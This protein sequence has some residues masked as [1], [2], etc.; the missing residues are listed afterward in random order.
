MPHNAVPNRCRFGFLEVIIA[1]ADDLHFKILL[2]ITVL[3]IVVVL[4]SV[5]RLESVKN[6]QRIFHIV[7]EVSGNKVIEGFYAV[8]EDFHVVDG[9]V[10]KY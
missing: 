3:H 1:N 8:V 4:R 7:V 9:S 2:P 10:M 5:F 6:S